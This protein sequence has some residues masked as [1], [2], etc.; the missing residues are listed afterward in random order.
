MQILLGT[1]GSS[2]ARIAEEL[3]QRIPEWREAEIVVASVAAPVSYS[4][5]SAIP[6]AGLIFADQAMKVHESGVQAARDYAEAAVTRLKLGGMKATAADLEGDAGSELLDFAERNLVEAIAIG[7]R[8]EGTYQSLLLG[9]VARKLVSHAPCHVLVGRSFEGK[10]AIESYQAIETK[11][12]LKVALGI[13]GSKGADLLLGYFKRQGPEAFEEL[14][15]VCAEPLGAIPSGIDP[16]SFVDLYDYDHQR[17]KETVARAA[18]GLAGLTA[19]DIVTACELGRP[20]NVIEAKAKEHGADLIAV[21]ATRHGTIE[22]FLI[23]SVSYELAT[24][25]PCSVFVIRP[26]RA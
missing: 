25:A 21:S 24:E 3:I 7:S 16:A 13:D 20:S 18:E 22:R 5:A 26:S 8:G 2:Y 1:D 11:S 14:I 10:S 6:G 19:S 23:G 12:K 4:I 9:S 15:A 17:A